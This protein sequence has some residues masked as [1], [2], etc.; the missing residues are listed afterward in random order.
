[1]SRLD[2]LYK[3][4]ETLRKEGLPITDELEK[5][6]NEIEE[7][8]IK[9]E[10]LPILTK[11]IEPALQP[12][13]REL[14]LIVDYIPGQ[15]LSVHL[16]RKRNFT[17]DM[18][19]AKEIVVDPEVIHRE[20][21]S[22]GN[23]DDSIQR[24]PARDMMVFFPDGTIIAEKKATETLV[25]VVKKIGVA[26]VRQVVEEHNLKLCKVP[27]ISNRRDAKYGKSQKDLGDGWLLITHSNNPMKKLFIEKISNILHLGIKVTLNQ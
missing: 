24:G 13:Q 19:D 14:V 15:P 22:H 7:E 2:D 25:K 3:A 21:G 26:K 8:I 18:P 27:V 4:M 6:A 10:I 16:S 5:K 1:M 17:A 20:Q 23:A 9:K 11:S 12:V